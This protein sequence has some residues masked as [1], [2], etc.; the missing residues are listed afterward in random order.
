M[1]LFTQ[2]T[3]TDIL[4]NKRR[5]NLSTQLKFYKFIMIKQNIKNNEYVLQ[6][7]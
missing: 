6:E 7:Y 1:S 3:N 4:L 5:R 2:T